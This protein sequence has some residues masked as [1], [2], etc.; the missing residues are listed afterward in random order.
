MEQLQ[1]VFLVISILVLGC[2][3]VCGMVYA[4]AMLI[5]LVRKRNDYIHGS[6]LV[7][8]RLDDLKKELWHD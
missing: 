8:N 6:K 3:L 4:L 1:Q 7:D 2:F 5:D